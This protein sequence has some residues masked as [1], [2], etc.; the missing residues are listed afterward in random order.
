MLMKVLGSAISLV[1]E[2]IGV[3]RPI[4]S[5][6]ISVHFIIIYFF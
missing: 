3:E 5:S 4:T 6:R 1:K 2:Q